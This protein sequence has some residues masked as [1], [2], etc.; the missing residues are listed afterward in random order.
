MFELF[1]IFEN[2][3]PAWTDGLSTQVVL[4][5]RLGSWETTVSIYSQSYSPIYLYLVSNG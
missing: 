3:P 5:N 1:P 4:A 2:R